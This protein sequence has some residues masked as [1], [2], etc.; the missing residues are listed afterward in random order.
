MTRA[1]GVPAADDIDPEMRADRA[2]EPQHDA[3]HADILD[4][5][6]LIQLT[7][8]AAGRASLFGTRGVGTVE[9]T[10]SAGIS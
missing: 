4:R 10:A 5:P 9:M 6:I 1:P 7:Q 8:R 2:L 3:D